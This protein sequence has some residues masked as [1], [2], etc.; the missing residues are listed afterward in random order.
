MSNSIS[1]VS[2]LEK[3][4]L[5]SDVPFLVCLD[6]LVV[7]RATAE[8]VDAL[9]L[10]KNNENIT[11]RGLLYTAV[12]FDIQAK[13]EVGAQ[14]SVTLTIQDLSRSVQSLMQQYGG[15]VGFRVAVFVINSSELDAPAEAVEYFKVISASAA[16]YVVSWSL[17]VENLLAVR[18]PRR[19]QMRSRCAWRFKDPNTCGYTGGLPT[20]DLTLE[21]PNGCRAHANTSRFGGFPGINKNIMAR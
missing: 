6:V 11:Y 19:L 12:S 4:K 20:C 5:S 21:G 3:S 2:A 9:R 14:P 15:G 8:V 18:F 1:I 13:Y 16:N 10:V 17:G 7:D